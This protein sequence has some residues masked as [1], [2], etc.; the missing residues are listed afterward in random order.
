MAGHYFDSALFYFDIQF[1]SVS[2]SPVLKVFS[3]AHFSFTPR[4]LGRQPQDTAVV[5]F[6]IPHPPLPRSH[7]TP[8]L[9]LPLCVGTL[10]SGYRSEAEAA[11]KH[12]GVSPIAIDS[13]KILPLQ[14]YTDPSLW[15][16]RVLCMRSS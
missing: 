5:R 13:I 16:S 9:R 12:E 14:T 10:M 11:L 1:C 7:L 15:T 8:S 3:V 4:L 2:S 6:R